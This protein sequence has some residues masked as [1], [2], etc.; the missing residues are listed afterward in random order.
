MSIIQSPM[1]WGIFYCIE[2]HIKMTISEPCQ[3]HN[4]THVVPHP[5][6]R[7]SEFYKEVITY[8]DKFVC[9]ISITNCIIL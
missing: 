6:I 7:K 4:F 9:Y 5:Y 8:Y 1:I 2:F 3:N